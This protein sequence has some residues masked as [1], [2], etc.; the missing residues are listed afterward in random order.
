MVDPWYFTIAKVVA[1]PAFFISLWNLLSPYI[2]SLKILISPEPQIQILEG[3]LQGK[4]ITAFNVLFTIIG[5]GPT[6]KWETYKFLTANLEI[7]NGKKIKFDCRSYLEEKGLGQSNASR[8]IPIPISG[9]TSKTTN[10]AFQSLQQES[11]LEGK[12]RLYIDVRNSGNDKLKCKGL[13]FT[14]D[15]LSVVKIPD[16]TI[17]FSCTII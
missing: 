3:D 7:P 4:R 13:E 1:I 11:W 17:I 5:K 2:L 15:N 14:I 16:S 6:T 12:Y 8:N 10:A 9:G